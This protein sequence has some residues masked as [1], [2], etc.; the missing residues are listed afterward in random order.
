MWI[1]HSYEMSQVPRMKIIKSAISAFLAALM[2]VPPA[3]ADSYIFRYKT[4]FV[5]YMGGNQPPVDEKDYDVT[6]SFIAFIGVQFA[7]R[8]PLKPGKVATRWEISSGSIPAGLSINQ[9][10]G[11]I[12]GTPTGRGVTRATLMGYSADGSDVSKVN[13]DF[14]V[15]DADPSSVEVD[16]TAHSDRFFQKQLVSAGQ[17]HTWE[18]VIAPPT[19]ARANGPNIEGTPPADLEGVF[20]YAFQGKDF[21]G[22]KSKFVHG[23]ITVSAGPVLAA[24]R[25]R[26]F[27]PKQSFSISTSA[28]NAIGKLQWGIQGD[29]L[30][31]GVSFDTTNGRLIGQ[32][33]TFSTST[34]QRF[35]AYD[36]DGTVGY[37][38]YFTVSTR[39]PNLDLRDVGDRT[40]YVNVPSSFALSAAELTGSP[41]WKLETGTLPNGISLD[42]AAGI[43]AGT[44]TETGVSEGLTISVSTSTGYSATSNPFKI[45]VAEKPITVAV[46]RSHVRVNTAFST[47]EPVV[48]DGR[49]PFVYALA[50]GQSAVDGLTLNTST[51]VLSGQLSEAGN[52]TVSMTVRDANGTVSSPFLVGINVYAPLTVSVSPAES[53]ITR[54]QTE[55]DIR[56]AYPK[57]ALIES[58]G[59]KLATFALTGTL[60][61]GLVFNSNIGLISGVA[62]RVGYY[63]PLSISVTDG[64]GET[65]LS[66]DFA[67]RVEEK[68]PLSIE[69]VR[70][71]FP[72]FASI[73]SP[74]AK[75]V[76]AANPVTWTLKAGTL[77]AGLTYSPDGV[78]IG[79]A[80]EQGRFSGLVLEAKDA[81]GATAS[82]EPFDL[83]ITPPEAIEITTSSFSWPVNKDFMS[84]IEVRNHAEPVVFS[85]K[86]SLPSGVALTKEGRLQGRVSA[87]FTGDIVVA[88]K[89]SMGRDAERIIRLQFTNAMTIA[90]D[91]AYSLNRMSATSIVPV[92]TNPIGAVSYSL[93][94]E[95]PNGLSFN[96]T[97]GEIYGKPT[98][99]GE[100]AQVTVAAVDAAGTQASA[101]T[102]LSVG[103]RKA[104]S[105]AY[106]FTDPLVQNSGAGLPKRPLEPNNI[107]GNAQ[108]TLTGTLPSGLHLNE[109]DGSIYGTPTAA[110]TVNNI[111]VS[112]R[113]SEGVQGAS[114]PFSITVN[115]AGQ[116]TVAS[117]TV[118]GRVNSW[119]QSPPAKVTGAAGTVT[120]KSSV[121][122]PLGL[123]VSSTDGSISGR[124]TSVGGG[125]IDITATDSTGRTA[126]FKVTVKIVDGLVVSYPAVDTINQ[127]AS[128]SLVPV[129]DNAIGNVAFEMS[130]SLPNGVTLDPNTGRISGSPTVVGGFSFLVKGTDEGLE[131]NNF[132][133]SVMTLNVTNRLDL[134]I[135][136]SLEQNL[137]ASRSYSQAAKA[138]NA[139][140][141]VTW[142][143]AGDLPPG[144]KFENG[145]FSGTP[146]ALG[147]FPVTLA[148]T[149]AVGG[150][151]SEEINFS[152]TTNGLPI[153][154]TTYNVQ[155]KAGMPFA[156]ELPLVRNN[157]GDY[158]FYMDELQSYGIKL[159]PVTGII[160][161]KFD[162]AIKVTGNIHVTDSTN[163]VTSKPITVEVIPN[164]R[165]TMREQI[166]ITASTEMAVVRP[167]TEYAIGTV[168]YE[169]VG[170]AL[171]TGVF[172]SKSTGNIS[173]TP[174]ALGEFKGY[175]VEAIDAVG[176]RQ[177]SNQFNITVYASGVLPTV[178]VSQTT[179]LWQASAS[180]H[181]LVPN[182]SAK[183]VGDVYSVNK[184]LPD[185]V[186]I[187]P[188][189]G[190]ISG[191]PSNSAVGRYD[192]YVITL[193]DTLGNEAKSNDF[194]IHIR[195]N[196][197]PSYAI[198]G[199][200]VRRGVPFQTGAARKLNGTPVGAVTF[201]GTNF[202][203]YLSI[204]PQTGV[205]SGTFPTSFSQSSL[206]VT[207]T[208]SDEIATYSN[209][210]TVISL[211]KLTATIPT[212]TISANAGAAVVSTTPV[213]TNSV[214]PVN[215]A[216]VAGDEVAGLTVDPTTGVITGTMPAGTF[217][218]RKVV[219]KDDTETATFIV[220]IRGGNPPAVFSFAPE[221]LTNV[222]ANTEFVTRPVQVTGIALQATVNLNSQQTRAYQHRIC[223]TDDCS[224]V[225]WKTGTTSRTDSILPGQFLQLKRNSSSLNGTTES[226]LVT[227]NGTSSSWS[228]GT[229]N[230]SWEVNTVDLG[231]SVVVNPLATAYSPTFQLTGFIDPN[232]IKFTVK[233]ANGVGS[234]SGTL[235]YRL[236]SDPSVCDD[237][238]ES[239]WAKA[240]QNVI[241]NITAGQ[242]V[243][244][245][246]VMASTLNGEVN[247]T[248]AYRNPSNGSYLTF[249]TWQAKVRSGSY[250]P[251]PVDLG[252][253]MVADPLE[254]KLSST[255]ELK[256]FLDPTRIRFNP[257]GSVNLRQYQV[258]STRESCDALGDTGW[259]NA[260]TTPIT[261]NPGT[262]LRLRI[263]AH[264]THG[265]SGSIAV[266]Y[267]KLNN[268]SYLDLASF[269]VSTRAASFNPNPVDF[270]PEISEIELSS[271]SKATIVQITGVLDIPT[272]KFV[273]SG[274]SFAAQYKICQTYEQC[275][276][277]EED[278]TSVWTLVSSGS[279]FKTVKP[280]EYIALR[281]QASAK[282]NESA[283]FTLAY[284]VNGGS[285]TFQ[286]IGSITFSSRAAQI[287]IDPLDFGPEVVGA[288][289]SVPTESVIVTLSGFKDAV[290]IR[291]TYTSANRVEYKTCD[292]L[293]VC[294]GATG[295]NPITNNGDVSVAATRKFMRLRVNY[296]TA[297]GNTA[298][299]VV[300]NK[301]GSEYVTIGTWKATAGN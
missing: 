79:I 205:I 38:N 241:I 176:D 220:N 51:G 22:A 257:L 122:N 248:G 170:P 301:R 19:W 210:T 89:D 202:P 46:K 217:D 185:G 6:A 10:T 109:T 17:V 297:A 73:H 49:A 242:Y 279:T 60:P 208:P 222:E 124:P 133:T 34:R 239:A 140:G 81:E 187:N 209:G 77:P 137:I 56:A 102:R 110:G 193:T 160:S 83:D 130:G 65:A 218:G 98:T 293:E 221:N 273:R 8:I 143:V 236:C 148:A 252:P 121:T 76:S 70:T 90:L 50:N 150:S 61:E 244:L 189:T 192:G 166:N 84:N 106:D 5:D 216:W 125:V 198:D 249:T 291:M 85:A 213:V 100:T 23:K 71:S 285:T 261:V 298:E 235:Y 67:I 13:V 87:P 271:W 117:S 96:K 66:N 215:F 21:T 136:I 14:T 104:I 181:S 295:W 165:V 156:S 245:K 97:N 25:D 101:S 105:I 247:V 254:W 161:G 31:T 54:L 27:D 296:F 265:N 2:I 178:K 199:V 64:S 108:W 230:T 149:D 206:S 48:T 167:I 72:V 78:L 128:V 171:P 42:T 52:K 103:A 118:V 294:E 7:N 219:V 75:A 246:A 18:P 126:N 4:G 299:I 179:Y 243:K 186:A 147:V 223:S 281:A 62:T 173:G 266:Q 3:Y 127:Y 234:G 267:D 144:I 278:T 226:I 229:R 99:E 53:V 269:T 37:S 63:G 255:V 80:R 258:C 197:L 40:L 93:I 9:E 151:A 116:F 238:N 228:I 283:T 20:S 227:I 289:L 207:F 82:T 16:V 162:E 68:A 191:I 180:R 123:Q 12:D 164:M 194:N 250:T 188:E 141:T 11:Q 211:V 95:L 290:T 35:V 214:G 259:T 157:V 231:D 43:I 138:K 158:S 203:N 224:D 111:V 59:T 55:V 260:T 44:P 30:P 277:A 263:Q 300:A 1:A 284:G 184:P 134:E 182:V 287:N 145:I 92:V 280:N 172:F 288:K 152:V 159:D 212:Q 196:P 268:S 107:V 195:S 276:L 135:A 201:R 264:Q 94:G 270:G 24:V 183:K 292:T 253:S 120:F 115:P 41:T 169:L 26:I 91:N 282:V 58:D 233:G 153:E 29:A 112:A 129:V 175:V 36:S 168:K 200:S 237:E 139:V 272:L 177:L 33:S 251:D 240:D 232:S 32:I 86:G 47:P 286:D 256:G 45:T 225:A 132:T 39:D 113:D 190:E 57:D 174:T 119:L 262:F 74:I 131:N 204:D 154:L 15:F 88:V 163:R 28:T 155:A 142:N 146:T 69:M 275:K 114:Q 274:A